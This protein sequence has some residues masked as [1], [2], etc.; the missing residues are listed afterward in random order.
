[1][2][3]YKYPHDYNNHYVKQ[4]YMPKELI[5]KSYYFPQSNKYEENIKNY[6]A[7]IKK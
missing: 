5:G 1:V 7:N 4:E 6:W 3:G 2:S